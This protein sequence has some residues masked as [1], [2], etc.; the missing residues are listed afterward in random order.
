MSIKLSH[1]VE[2]RPR[3]LLHKTVDVKALEYGVGVKG[4]GNDVEEGNTKACVVVV[5][6]LM[7]RESSRPTPAET[8]RNV[9]FFYFS[10]SSRCWLRERLVQRVK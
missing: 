2:S 7:T 5:V 1:P 8:E 4:D 3:V 10:S 6:V 9:I